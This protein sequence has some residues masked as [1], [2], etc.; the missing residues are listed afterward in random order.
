MVVAAATLVEEPWAKSSADCLRFLLPR[1]FGFWFNF[2]VGL[3]VSAVEGLSASSP[4]T[5][6]VV[7][8][9]RV[10]LGFETFT[11]SPCFSSCY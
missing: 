3:L 6:C 7:N 9:E 11:L 10:V 4:D 2:L 8:A 5:S 1:F